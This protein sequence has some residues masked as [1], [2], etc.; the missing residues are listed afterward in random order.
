MLLIY[1]QNITSRHHYIFQFILKEMLGLEFNFTDSKVA[2]EKYEG[3]KLNYSDEEFPGIASVKPFSLLQEKGI[4]Q[5]DVSVSEYAGVKSFFKTSGA[6]NFPFD[7]FSAAFFLLSRYEEY[8]P[9]EIEKADW[10]KLKLDKHGRY[11][12]EESLAYKSVFLQQPV[13]NLWIN[14][15]KDYLKSF[16]PEILY[17][18]HSYKFISTIDVD[19]GYAFKGKSFIKTTGGIVKSILKGNKAEAMLRLK[20]VLGL[21]KDPFDEYDYQR[22]LKEEFDLEMI[23]FMLCGIG[24]HY[25]HNIQVFS[26]TFKDL[27]RKLQSFSGLGL[28]PSYA[29][30]FMQH[31][32]S[33]EKSN[34]EIISGRE[35]FK[36]RQHFLKMQLPDTYQ[37]LIEAGI[38]EDYSMGYASQP[39][40]RAGIANPF[41]FYNL[42][43]EEETQLMLHPF[44]AMEVTFKDYLKITADESFFQIQEIVK[45]IKD[46]DGTFVSIW[47]DRTFAKSTEN[48]PWI[49][50][51]E[52]MLNVAN[53]H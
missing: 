7:L 24:S 11:T 3:K 43:K 22:K 12:A 14:Q 33:N 47:H 34:L 48:I 35:V 10:E 38:K 4:R 16:Y 37:Q 40:F 51:Y 25:D 52:E 32:V 9:A 26:R 1:S 8:C 18:K 53:Q 6:N 23:Y 36:S 45:S 46:V 15:F 49:N 13:V 2:F 42:L 31:G 19:N 41:P 44:Q 30:H 50:L 27:V 39:G 17:K 28:H 21:T 29:S 5:F 20:V